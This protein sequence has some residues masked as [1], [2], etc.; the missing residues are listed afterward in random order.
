MP[1]L[2]TGIKYVSAT[3]LATSC[4]RSQCYYTV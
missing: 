1:R 4:L 2:M 3:V